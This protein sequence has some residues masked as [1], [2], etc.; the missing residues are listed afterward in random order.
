VGYDWTINESNHLS[1]DLQVQNVTNRQGRIDANQLYDT[2]SF[3]ADGSPI[4]NPSYGASTWQAPRTTMLIA[5]YTF[6]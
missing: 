1:L 4:L 5:R 2:G 3:Q 6:R